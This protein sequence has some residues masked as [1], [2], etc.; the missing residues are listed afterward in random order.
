MDVPKTTRRNVIDTIK[1]QGEDQ[2]YNLLGY[3]RAMTNRTVVN[4]CG[5]HAYTTQIHLECR[6]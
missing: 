3:D 4:V 6:G 2:T 5:N 1:M